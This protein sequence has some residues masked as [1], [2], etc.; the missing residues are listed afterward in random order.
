[1]NKKYFVIVLLVV[2]VLCSACGNNK[3]DVVSSVPESS[4]ETN[5]NKF[6]VYKTNLDFTDIES[7]SEN[8][9][10]DKA[11]VEEEKSITGW[12]TISIVEF[13]TKYGDLWQ[14]EIDEKLGVLRNQLGEKSLIHLEESQKAWG[15]FRD[16][17]IK[18]L[19]EHRFETLGSGTGIPIDLSMKYL[20]LTRER[21]LY[22][23]DYCNLLN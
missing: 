11:F 8:H 19:S 4:A 5:E 2:L 9:P 1:V 18:L 22:L 21:A 3:A 16:S 10:I 13:H 6:T 17:E 15:I 23:T 20:E 7:I 14:A 12:T